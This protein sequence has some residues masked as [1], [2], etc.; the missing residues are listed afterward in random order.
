[1]EEIRRS[2][3]A[4]TSAA[5]RAAWLARLAQSGQPVRSFAR[6]HGLAES[7]VYRWL[8]AARQ[9]A[10]PSSPA[11]STSF[12]TLDL[13][14]PEPAGWAGRPVTHTLYATLAISPRTSCSVRRPNSS[15]HPTP[16]HC[17][18]DLSTNQAHQERD[19]HKFQYHN[20]V[21]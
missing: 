20:G 8:W 2:R 16:R 10:S 19:E 7:K 11:A 17:P 18:G 14:G 1:M 4:R 13:S 15:S 12:A 21:D 3:A 6:E 5:Q 9:S